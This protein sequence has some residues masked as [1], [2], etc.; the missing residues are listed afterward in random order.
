MCVVHAAAGGVGLLLTQM[1]KARGGTVIATASTEEKREL[2]RAAGADETIGYEGFGDVRQRARRRPRDLRR[3]RRDDVRGGHGRAAHAR[4]LRP[5]R[6]GE[7]PGA[8]VGPAAAEPEV[9]VPDP[10]RACPAT[11]PRARSSCARAGEVFGWIADGSLD[12]RIGERYPLA[13][14]V[15]AHED[16]EARRTTGKLLLIP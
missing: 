4:L 3:D 5:L 9:A 1:I 14:A 10:A 7:R 8:R 11:P 13:D 6:D 15:R 12:V 2:A 16:L